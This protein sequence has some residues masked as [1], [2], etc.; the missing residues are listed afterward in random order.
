M[1]ELMNGQGGVILFDCLPKN[2]ELLPKGAKLTLD[3]QNEVNNKLKEYFEDLVNN[4][5]DMNILK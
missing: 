1:H 4:D 3:R 2:R 5:T